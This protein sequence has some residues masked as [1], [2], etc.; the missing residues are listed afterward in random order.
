MALS[1]AEARLAQ[2]FGAAIRARR[3]AL[4]HSQADLA[5]MIGTNRRFV[6]ELERGKGTSYLAPALAAAEALG[7]RI[8]NLFTDR[9]L[10]FGPK[11]PP[12]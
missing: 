3:K 5:G 12:L 11:L 1:T 2:E 10:S 8:G 6:S 9:P 4:G 7:M